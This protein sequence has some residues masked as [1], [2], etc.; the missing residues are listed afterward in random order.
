VWHGQA[1]LPTT[2]SSDVSLNLHFQV[3]PSCFLHHPLQGVVELY[4]LTFLEAVRLLL[5]CLDSASVS[6]PKK[7]PASTCILILMSPRVTR[8]AAARLSAGSIPPAEPPA[9]P[10]STRKRKT[11]G[12]EHSSPDPVPAATSEQP[13]K[14]TKRQKV[15]SVLA[16]WDAPIVEQES[17]QPPKSRRRGRVAAMSNTG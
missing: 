12:R 6:P 3:H 10:S 17:V 13:Q 1:T 15:E 14:R 9:A 16:D 5:P 4:S 2:T 8:S 7:P 11:R